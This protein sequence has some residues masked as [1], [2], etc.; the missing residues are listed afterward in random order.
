[1]TTMHVIIL[2]LIQG[3]TEFLPI[4]SSAHLILPSQLLGWTDQG[5]VFD[6]TVHLGTLL[7]VVIY[8]YK[9]VFGLLKAWFG[10]L[11]G[12]KATPQSRLAWMIILATIPAVLV[13]ALC[14]DLIESYAR[15]AKVI[16]VTTIVFGL[17][18]GWVDI[19]APQRQDEYNMGWKH[20]LYVGI[21]QVL[22]MIPGTSRSGITMTAA[23][24][25]G[26]TREASARFSFLLSIPV[27]LGAG[28]LLAVQVAQSPITVPWHQLGL[29]LV[30][31]FVS[32]LACIHYFMRWVTQVGMI[33]FVIYRILLGIVLALVVF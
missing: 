18:L 17:L 1:M 16:A 26:Y 15:S 33:P 20:A 10:S 4:S 31:S 9:D 22:A 28:S 27:I 3:L 5:E 32:A 14:S 6:V 7:A 29:G 13:G 19:K 30:V 12:K 25:L 11:T 24:Q 23:R 21:A 2:S 8:F